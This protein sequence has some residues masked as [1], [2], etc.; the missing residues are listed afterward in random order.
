MIQIEFKLEPSRRAIHP[1]G[2][3]GF[4]KFPPYQETKGGRRH[5]PLQPSPS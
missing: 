1:L 2:P 3:F 4:L 5:T